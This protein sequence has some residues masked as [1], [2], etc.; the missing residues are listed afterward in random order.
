[1]PSL[2]DASSVVGTYNAEARRARPPGGGYD[3]EGALRFGG[4]DGVGGP[5]RV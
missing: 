5:G 3:C 2:S 4:R 1:M